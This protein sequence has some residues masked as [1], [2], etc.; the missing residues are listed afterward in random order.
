MDN[1]N[2]IKNGVIKNNFGKVVPNLWVSKEWAK[3]F[4]IFI[5]RLLDGKIPKIIEIHPPY[6]KDDNLQ[7]FPEKYEIFYNELKK[8]FTIKF[9]KILIENRNFFSLSGVEDFKIL[10][11]IIDKEKLDL[12]LILDFPQLLN[13][14]KVR[15][16]SKKLDSIMESIEHF[17]HNVS[18]FHLWGQIN[19]KT[20]YSIAHH[21]DLDDYFTKNSNVPDKWV[22]YKKSNFLKHLK[23]LFI[24]TGMDDKIIYFIPEINNGSTGKTSTNCL[25]N[26]VNDLQ[27]YGFKFY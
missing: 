8:V 27:Q 21:G 11:D 17:K 14:H 10:S 4:A 3:E 19:D 7:D 23:K 22:N 9:P 12:Q 24:N 26:I 13:Y 6:H 20:K 18:A 16:Y 25:H 15:D 1:L 5:I 2:H